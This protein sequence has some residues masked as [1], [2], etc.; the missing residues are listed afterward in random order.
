MSDNQDIIQ[1][2]KLVADLKQQVDSL[3]R[4]LGYPSWETEKRQRAESAANDAEVRAQTRHTVAD[5]HGG[6]PR[7]KPFDP[8]YDGGR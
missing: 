7:P 8:N 6:T 1:L 5:Q 3:H 4:K 2:Q